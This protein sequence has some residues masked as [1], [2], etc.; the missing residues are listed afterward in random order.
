VA[1]SPAGFGFCLTTWDGEHAVP[2]PWPAGAGTTRVD[3]LCIDIPPTEFE[4]ECAFWAALTGW[5]ATPAPF[6]EY[7]FLRVPDELPIRIILQRLGDADTAQRAR[8][9]VD[10]GAPDP[11]TVT[12]HVALG[13]RVVAEQEHWTVL[14][15][16]ADREYCL[17]RR[18][19]IT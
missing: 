19:P 6:P 10:F 17:V 5:E 15:D 9:H 8:G 14:A 16:P 2:S 7:A 12:A 3:T 13:A 18:P 1:R 4:R 11:A